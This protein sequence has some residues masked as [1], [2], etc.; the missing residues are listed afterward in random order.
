[1]SAILTQPVRGPVAWS[2]R[3]LVEDDSVG[4]ASERP[5]VA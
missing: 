4:P 5:D 2:G 3:D 1:M